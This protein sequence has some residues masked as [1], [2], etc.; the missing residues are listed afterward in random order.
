MTKITTALTQQ[1]EN[2]QISEK[3]WKQLKDK[4]QGLALTDQ[5]LAIQLKNPRATLTSPQRKTLKDLKLTKKNK[6]S[7]AAKL[8]LMFSVQ[9]KKGDTIKITRWEN[10]PQK[11]KKVIS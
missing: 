10:F 1:S 4:F 2:I 9:I 11:N 7:P 5:K 3:K 6:L 8:F